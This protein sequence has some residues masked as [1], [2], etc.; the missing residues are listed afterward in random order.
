ME[1]SNSATEP[2]TSVT[3]PTSVTI[4]SNSMPIPRLFANAS[5]SGGQF[6]IT[7]NI[8]PNSSTNK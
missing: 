3:E 8:Q 4:Q 5:I 7:I 2:S 6:N 1:P